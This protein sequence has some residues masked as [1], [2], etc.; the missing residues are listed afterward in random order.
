MRNWL[1]SAR[2]WTVVQWRRFKRW[3]YGILIALG[4]V[5]G[6]LVYSEIVNFTYTPASQRV[7]GTPMALS[8]IAET[9]LYCDGSLITSEP[10]ADSGISGDLGLGSHDCYATH[11]DTAGQESDPSNIVTRIVLPARPGAPVLDQ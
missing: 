6:G 2:A 8:E 1:R 10:G 11:V 5:T 4:L 3:A 9:R 7:D